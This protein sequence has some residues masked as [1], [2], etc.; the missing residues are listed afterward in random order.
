M[1]PCICVLLIAAG[2]LATACAPSQTSSRPVYSGDASANQPIPVP[3]IG[4]GG[5]IGF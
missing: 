2:M 4:L 1:K 3:G 5:L